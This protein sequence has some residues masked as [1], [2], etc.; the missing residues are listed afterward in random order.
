[1]QW[2]SFLT[3]ARIDIRTEPLLLHS[4]HLRIPAEWCE[5]TYVPYLFAHACYLE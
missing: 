2:R 3:V 5:S 4:L 1:M